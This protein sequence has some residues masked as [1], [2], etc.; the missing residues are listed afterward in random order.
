MFS[1]EIDY[2]VCTQKFSEKL[3]NFLLPG[4][5][6]SLKSGPETL[7]P[8]D[9]RPGTLELKPPDLGPA[10]MSSKILRPRP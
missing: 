5:W 10:I 2:L 1:L 8:G 7:R 3:T 9:L 4:M 6:H